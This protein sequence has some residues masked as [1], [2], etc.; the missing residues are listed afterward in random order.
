MG[1]IVTNIFSHS[2]L[3]IQIWIGYIL[4]VDLQASIFKMECK[5]FTLSGYLTFLA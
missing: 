5:S 2:S 3:R 1:A 4:N